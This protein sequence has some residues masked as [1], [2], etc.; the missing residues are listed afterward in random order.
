MKTSLVKYMLALFIGVSII[1]CKENAKKAE[2]QVEAEPEMEV[3]NEDYGGLALY[4]V[5]EDMGKNAK[6]TLQSV[7]DAGYA[8]IEAAGYEEGKFYE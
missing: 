1:S 3:S 4:T 6:S 2:E 7:A 8:Y 5:R